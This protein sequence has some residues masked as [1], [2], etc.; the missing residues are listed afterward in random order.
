MTVA[1]TDRA[2]RARAAC[3]AA[4]APQFLPPAAGETALARCGREAAAKAICARCEVR[5][6]CL[7][8]AVSAREPL[9]V[10]GGLNETER[11]GLSLAE[12]GSA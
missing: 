3:R 8:Y 9:G 2:W 5:R 4:D 6:E 1:V 11:S 7:A 12:I 10:W